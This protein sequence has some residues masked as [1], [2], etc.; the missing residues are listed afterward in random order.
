MQLV[1]LHIGRFSSC[2]DNKIVPLVLVP[3][4]FGLEE[5]KSLSYDPSCAASF[6]CVAD[7]FRCDYA[8]T[9]YPSFV[10]SEVAHKGAVHNT[11]AL[12]KQITELPILFYAYVFFGVIHSLVR[13]SCSAL[14][15]SAGDY[16]SAVACG[17]SFSEAVL[18]LSLTLFRLI[19]SLH[20]KSS[21]PISLVV[22]LPATKKP[23]NG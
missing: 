11:C 6:N 5:P 15:T 12:F 19:S 17:H 18:H 8:Q 23:F 13:K 7:F 10:W 22:F 21:F 9:V 14:G 20:F 2:N 3:P 4:Y 1:G 16:L